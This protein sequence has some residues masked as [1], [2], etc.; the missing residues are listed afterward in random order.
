MIDFKPLN[1]RSDKQLNVAGIGEVV[2]DIFPGHRTLG[3]A[4]YNYAFHCAQLSACA[5]IV[6]GIGSDPL[7]EDF[8]EVAAGKRLDVSCVQRESGFSTG[9]VSVTLSDGTPSYAVC[10]GAAWDHLQQT[11]EL[12]ALAKRMGAVCFGTLGQRNEQSR[13]TIQAFVKACPETAVKILDINLRQNFFSREVIQSSLELAN[14]LKI[15]DEE[16]PVLKEMFRL[17]GDVDCQL[18]DL[19]E[20]FSLRL[21][22]YT[23]GASGSLLV[24]PREKDDHPGCPGKAVDTVG[25]GDSFTA[26][27]SMGLF[28]GWP[29]NEMNEFANQVATFVCSQKGATPVLPA[30]LIQGVPA[31]A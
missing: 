15:S 11:T 10:P 22:A 6:S 16:L 12:F 3:G 8:L 13:S 7:G 31:Y 29:L 18:A 4:P 5:A 28:W 20:T 9:Q 19:V 30:E 21:V 1:D 25:A 27:L 17:T 26:A 14:I 2:W 23:R 24:T